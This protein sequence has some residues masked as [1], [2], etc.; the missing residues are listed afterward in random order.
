M[1]SPLVTQASRGKTSLQK[2]SAW[3]FDFYQAGQFY[4]VDYHYWW[5]P[6]QTETGK[7]QLTMMHAV[8]YA[9]G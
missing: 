9:E 8:A 7:S 5:H 1:L 4:P 3:A 6:N 2:K